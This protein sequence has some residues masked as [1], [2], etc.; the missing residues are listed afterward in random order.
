MTQLLLTLWWRLCLSERVRVKSTPIVFQAQ[1]FYCMLLFYSAAQPQVFWEVPPVCAF[2]F[3]PDMR[4]LIKSKL[5]QTKIWNSPSFKKPPLPLRS[6]FQ[7]CLF[8]L[9]VCGMNGKTHFCVTKFAQVKLNMQ[10]NMCCRNFF[11]MRIRLEKQ[12][13]Q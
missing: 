3:F 11:E 8:L 1:R 6:C 4:T 12:K 7:C 2:H 10:R 9:F 13:M 5:K